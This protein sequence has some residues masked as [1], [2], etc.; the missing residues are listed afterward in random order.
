MKT[1][2]LPPGSLGLELEASHRS[3]LGKQQ[4]IRVKGW[5]SAIF[6]LSALPAESV[7]CR[8]DGVDIHELPFKEAVNLLKTSE[9]R[10]IE[11]CMPG[12]ADENGGGKDQDKVLSS[13]FGYS[14]LRPRQCVEMSA[15]F[16]FRHVIKMIIL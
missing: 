3:L 9:T 13:T 2:R 1:V 15:I 5:K 10:E 6:S 16:Q 8:I 11:Y 14:S 12:E 7:V 4:G